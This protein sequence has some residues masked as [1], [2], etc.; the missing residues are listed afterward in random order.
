MTAPKR[1]EITGQVDDI[2]VGFDVIEGSVMDIMKSL[3]DL[4]TQAINAGYKDI[5]FEYYSDWDDY[6]YE[7]YGTRLETDAEHKKRLLKSRGARAKKKQ[8]KID[9]ELKDAAE[10]ERLKAKFG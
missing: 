4:E 3:T 9:N 8:A 2:Y 7:M 1:K 10:Y 5:R 6:S